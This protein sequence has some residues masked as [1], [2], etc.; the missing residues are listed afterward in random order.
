MT[1][2]CIIAQVYLPLVAAAQTPASAQ[3]LTITITAGRLANTLADTP[4]AASVLTD[5][6]LHGGRQQLG[7]DEVLAGVPGVFAVNRYNFAQDLRLAIRGF[8]ARA[9]FGIRGVRIFIDGIPATTPDGQS[10]IDDIDLAT[11]Q[12]IEIIRGPAGALYGPSAGG[13]LS[14]ETQRSN[15]PNPNA[16]GSLKSGAY[17]VRELRFK[18]N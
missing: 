9:N 13:V 8:G 6:A 7:L 10:S 15:K 4:A 18:G 16:A 1:V 3:P 11:L 17:G 2:L 14:L 12:R 5:D